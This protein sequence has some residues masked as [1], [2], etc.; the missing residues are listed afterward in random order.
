LYGTS[1]LVDTFFAEKKKREK[2]MNGHP[3]RE[4]KGVYCKSH[5]SDPVMHC[6]LCKRFWSPCCGETHACPEQQCP[7]VPG[8]GAD[9]V[10]A[11][12]RFKRGGR[13][14]ARVSRPSPDPLEGMAWLGWEM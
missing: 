5:A 9:L 14:K 13:V 7:T 6:S 2:E 8:S 3:H 4:A 10:P 11:S 1:D 12:A